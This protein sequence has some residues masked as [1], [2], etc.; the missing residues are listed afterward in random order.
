MTNTNAPSV[1]QICARLDGLPLAIELAA[2]RSKILPPPALLRRLEHRF[3]LLIGG[4]QDAP[5]RQRTLYNTIAW[6]YDLLMASE[7][8]LFRRLCVFVGGATL[9]A[10]EAVSA[11]LGDNPESVLD[12][13]ASLVDKSLLRQIEPERELPR[14]VL[15]ETIREYGWEAL[16]ASGEAEITRQAHAADYLALAEEAAPDLQGPQTGAWMR[17]LEQEHDNLRAAMGWSLE[18]GKAA[19]ALRMGTALRWFPGAELLVS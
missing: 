8:R 3:P 4:G 6:S 14:F 11:A 15:L 7:Q 10:V 17:R 2:A 1:A 9:S 12:G 19:M 16:I 5:L 18:R 13:I